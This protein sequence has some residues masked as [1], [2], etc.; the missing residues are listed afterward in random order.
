VTYAGTGTTPN[1][2]VVTATGVT[3]VT[4]TSSV[5][6][7]TLTFTSDNVATARDAAIA[8][9]N[10]GAW[11][12]KVVGDPA[13]SLTE[14][15][16]FA[17]KSATTGVTLSSGVNAIVRA[18][19]NSAFATAAP[20]GGAV[21]FANDYQFFSGGS[22]GAVPTL[23]DWTDAFA[24]A[25][26][27]DVAAVAV[28]SGDIGVAG[29]ARS[30]VYSM[31]T[32]RARKERLAY[33]GPNLTTTKAAMKTAALGLVTAVGGEQI[34]IA[35]NTVRDYSLLTGT[36]TQYPAYYLACYAAATKLTGRPEESLTNAPVNL[37]GLGYVLDLDDIE[38]LLIGG[39]MPAHYDDE[40]NKNVITQGITSYTLDANAT[41]RKISGMD[42]KFYLQKK[43]RIRLKR[44]VGKPADAA[45]ARAIRKEVIKA[46]D[47]E[48]RGALYPSGVLTPGTDI[49]TGKA[50]A[51]YRNLEVIFDGFDFTGVDFECS[52]VGTNEYIGVRT[53]FVPVQISA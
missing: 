44:F 40:E 46:L 9:A 53:S 51:A 25:E 14:L 47:E 34:V 29:I 11:T 41:L 28:G 8:I 24:L 21:T 37:P 20:A 4:F 3:T 49:D 16:P 10:S 35:G 6:S 5:P 36:L 2:A 50:V 23:T 19:T 18:L 17:S 30:H 7:E 15:T 12:A 26:T 38:E 45:G 33:L 43:L 42:V 39:V 32:I 27:L 1:A 22:E 48:V 52:P 31:S 13:T